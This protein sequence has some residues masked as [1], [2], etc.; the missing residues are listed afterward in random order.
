MNRL[1]LIASL[2]SGAKILCDV[3]C[4]HAYA[5]EMAL[6]KYDVLRGIASDIN[7]M[8]LENAKKTLSK[9]NL[10]DRVDFVLSNGF[11]NINLEFDT[12]I[13]SGM[14]GI[15]IK[16]I[17]TEALEKIKDK[18]LILS[19]NTD[20]MIV[21]KF[22]N[23]NNFKIIEEYAIIDQKK[24]YEIIKAIPGE[25]DLTE[26]ELEFGPIL[27]KNKP[28]IFINNIKKKYEQLSKIIDNVNSLEEKNK[29][30]EKLNNYKEVFMEKIFI[31]NTK[32]YYRTYFLDN[33]K[34]DLV[35]ISAGGGYEYTSIRESEPVGRRYND[36]G[37]HVVI[38][39]YREDINELYPL[40]SKY[41]AYVI[42]LF[43]NDNRVNKIIGIG[44]SAGGHNMLE[45]SLHSSEYEGN[46]KPD[47]LILGYP[48]VTSDKRYYHEGSF[49]H[50]LGDGFDDE[51]LMK[52]LSME[53]EVNDRAPDLFL[54]GTITDTSVDVMNSLLLIEA[55]HKHNCNVEYHLFPMGPH[56]LSVA[57]EETAQGNPEKNN[58]YIA[59][60]VDL[61]LEWLKLKLNK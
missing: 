22:L 42:N 34:R 8:P 30:I 60:W 24:Y 53:N 25:M 15:L 17:L 39:N 54:W 20:V 44:F 21:R 49:R 14:G 52:H 58:P 31:N 51:K 7:E 26:L 59:R 10:L 5:L 36:A 9:A 45:V 35:V 38:V 43:R 55:Y 19:P 29:I 46:A 11:E 61:S 57:R 33:E 56:G 48:V 41:L 2:S 18:T 3:G 40:P 32:N 6:T 37:Y 50:L 12:A 13:I 16:D 23:D 4:D 47:L 1:N 28:E 27:L